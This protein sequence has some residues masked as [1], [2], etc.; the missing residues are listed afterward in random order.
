MA[1][2]SGSRAYCEDF[3][4]QSESQRGI[5]AIRS[6]VAD[7][8]RYVVMAVILMGQHAITHAFDDYP[9]HIRPVGLH[10]EQRERDRARIRGAC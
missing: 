9:K 7:V 1:H 5:V 6:V 4:P 8:F 3:R 10:G 2:V